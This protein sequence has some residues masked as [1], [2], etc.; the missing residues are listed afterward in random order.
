MVF[1]DPVPLYGDPV[2]GIDVS[3]EQIPGGIR[4]AG[5]DGDV[6]PDCPPSC[7]GTGDEEWFA[8]KGFFAP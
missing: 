7:A 6:G 5:P 8:V 2:P 4:D 3:L 1:G